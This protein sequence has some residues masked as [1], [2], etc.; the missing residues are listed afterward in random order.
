MASGQGLDIPMKGGQTDDGIAP[1]PLCGGVH[2]FKGGLVSDE[3]RHLWE[4]RRREDD[5]RGCFGLV[6]L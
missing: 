2:A 4:R 5:G 1:M 3:D 6:A